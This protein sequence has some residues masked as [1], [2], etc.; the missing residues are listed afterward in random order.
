MGR[1][2]KECCTSSPEASVLGSRLFEAY[3]GWCGSRQLPPVSRIAF[4]RALSSLGYRRRRTR[5]ARYWDGLNCRLAE[6]PLPAKLAL[7]RL[8]S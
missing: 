2:V 7:S 3:M 4:A 5:M 8:T 1:F 6:E